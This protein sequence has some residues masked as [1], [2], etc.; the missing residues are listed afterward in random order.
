MSKTG[1]HAQGD[2]SA[3]RY[4]ETK[5]ATPSPEITMRAAT[6]TQILE[7]DIK[8]EEQECPSW[9]ILAKQ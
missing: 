5:N 3:R 2:A 7:A 4:L 8:A 9:V 1:I 6:I